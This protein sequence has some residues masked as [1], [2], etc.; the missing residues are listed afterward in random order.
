MEDI[1]IQASFVAQ[2]EFTLHFKADSNGSISGDTL[3]VVDQ[4]LNAEEVI[5]LPNQGY[6]FVA[7]LDELNQIFS[8]EPN[9]QILDV[10]KNYELTAKF[11]INKYQVLG[12]NQAA[13]GVLFIDYNLVEHGDT[14][15]VT[16]TPASGNGL[17]SLYL[18]GEKFNSQLFKTEDGFTFELIVTSDVFIKPYFSKGSR[19]SLRYFVLPDFELEYGRNGIHILPEGSSELRWELL[20][21]QGRTLRSGNVFFVPTSTIQNGVYLLR[22]W[23]GTTVY[24]RSIWIP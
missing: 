3:Q 7:W 10:L 16:I 12:D 14:V 11:S 22:I 1:S 21:L 20:D 17:D 18:N 6:H 9:I 19:T 13:G 15:K 24:I 8:E 23:Q 2:D 5:A 4:G